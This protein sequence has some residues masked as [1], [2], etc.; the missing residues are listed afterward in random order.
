HTSRHTIEASELIKREGFILGLQ[1][2][3]GLPLSDRNSD[4]ETARKIAALGPDLVRIYPTIIIKNTHLETMYR[5]GKYEPQTLEYMIDLC[6]ELVEI[7][8]KEGIDIARIGLQSSENMTEEKEIVAGPYHPAFGQLVHSKRA[9]Q[10][11]MK[12]IKDMGLEGGR[13]SIRVPEKEL[14]TYI[15][16]K[17]FNIE[18]LKELFAF[19]DVRFIPDPQMDQGFDIE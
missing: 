1:T 7:Y 13:I 5:Q 4:I 18:K 12:S 16:Q 10:E 14:S 17:R 6:V 3:P 15:G 9:L 11:V 2:M 8:E 19:D